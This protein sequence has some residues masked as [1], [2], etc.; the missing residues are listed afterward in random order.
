MLLFKEKK[1][2]AQKHTKQLTEYV[3]ISIFKTQMTLKRFY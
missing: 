1:I 3:T 2:K